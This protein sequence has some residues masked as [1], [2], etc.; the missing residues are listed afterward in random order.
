MYYWGLVY[1]ASPYLC[2]SAILGVN[3]Q[4]YLTDFLW[5]SSIK[6]RCAGY[7]IGVFLSELPISN[8]TQTVHG[9]QSFSPRNLVFMQPIMQ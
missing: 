5:A 7:E 1:H 2:F 3:A 4:R 9:H 6:D 8:H